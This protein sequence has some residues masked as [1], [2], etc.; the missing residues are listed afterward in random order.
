MKE[1]VSEEGSKGGREGMILL[2]CELVSE[3]MRG[4]GENN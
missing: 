2:V 1:C 4:K 3:Q